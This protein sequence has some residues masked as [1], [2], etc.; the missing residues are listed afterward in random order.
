MASH[1]SCVWIDG[2]IVPD[3]QPCI[4][5]RDRGFLVGHGAFET[6]RAYAGI[7]FALTRH[8]KRLND[9]CAHLGL[10]CP[11]LDLFGQ[12]MHDVL[13]SNQL[14]DARVRFTVSGGRSGATP[15]TVQNAAHVC[16][17]VPREPARE[18]ESVMMAP[19]PRNER[20]A[21]TG[22]KA[23]SY[24]ENVV[25]LQLAHQAGHGEAV[26]ANTRSDLCEGTATNVFLIRG[27][28]VHTPPL[29][30]GCLPG[31][32]RALVLDVCRASGIPVSEA[33]L[34]ASALAE[35]DEA[36]L[37]SSMREV[38]P[39]SAVDGTP[40]SVTGGLLTRRI[41]GLYRDL[42]SSNHDP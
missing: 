2:K 21:L 31:I 33:P 23:L 18:S 14:H 40:L 4:S 10:P 7:P 22:A 15:D 20:G 25:A 35:A 3:D 1:E 38:Q 12:A 8:W 26:F 28:Q 13:N 37:T 30:S 39:I 34:P 16:T 5:C 9:S 41:A 29:A 42:V 19:W 24:G 6:L 17:A 11:S 36:F 32:T 27:G